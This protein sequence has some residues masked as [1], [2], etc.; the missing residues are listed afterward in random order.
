[1]D[2]VRG[3]G[4]QINLDGAVVHADETISEIFKI[5]GMM[6]VRDERFTFLCN[7]EELKMIDHLAKHLQRSRSDAIRF[8]IRNFSEWVIKRENESKTTSPLP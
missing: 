4:G 6:T 1:M 7:K 3:L 2:Y 5:G 8:V